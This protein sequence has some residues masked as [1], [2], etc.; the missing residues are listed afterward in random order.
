MIFLLK[1]LRTKALSI[2]V[3]CR[4]YNIVREK[5]GRSVDTLLLP[6][7][8]VLRDMLRQLQNQ[9]G[10]VFTKYLFYESGEI[11]PYI[12]IMKKGQFIQANA[13]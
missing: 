4:Y 3:V 12:R 2:Q 6:E 8:S 13:E 10:S 9:Y 11:R 7:G 5:S 1:S